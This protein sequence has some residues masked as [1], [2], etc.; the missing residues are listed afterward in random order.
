MATLQY[1]AADP[2]GGIG[3]NRSHWVKSINRFVSLFGTSGAGANGDNSVRAYDPISNVWSYLKPNTDPSQTVQNRDNHV[4]LY[5]HALDQIWITG[6]SHLE[7]LPAGTARVSGRFSVATRAWINQDA[8]IDTPNGAFVGVI[9]N[10]IFQFAAAIDPACDWSEASNSGLIFGGS[11]QGNPTNRCFIIEPN[12]AGPEPYVMS[13]VFGSMPPPRDQ[14]MNIMVAVG[15]DW[16]LF[17]GNSSNT[18]TNDFWKFTKATRQWTRLPDPP[19][20]GGYLQPA[21][22]YDS[23]TREILVWVNAR[24]FI[25]NIASNAWRTDPLVVPDTGN[26]VC[27]YSPTGKIHIFSGGSNLNT[28]IGRYETVGVKLDSSTPPPSTGLDIAPGTWKALPFNTTNAPAAG[29]GGKH[30]RLAECSLNG[31]V[32][33]CGGDYQTPQEVHCWFGVWAVDLITNTWTIE[34]PHMGIAGEIMPPACDEVGWAWD[35]KRK[36]F[37]MLPG[38]TIVPGTPL[39]ANLPTP[40]GTVVQKILCFDPVAKKWSDPQVPREPFAGQLPKNATYDSVNDCIWRVGVDQRGTV[41]HRLDCASKT[42]S[43]YQTVTATDGTYI[44][45]VGLDF[46]YIAINPTTQKIYVIDPINYRLFEFDCTN[47]AITI[48]APIPVIDAA[49]VQVAKNRNPTMGDLT[50]VAVDVANNK[51]LYSMF[52]RVLDGQLNDA[53]SIV[54]L[55]IFD[56]PTNTWTIDPMTQPEGRVVRGN[57]LTFAPIN[58]ALVVIGGLRQDAGFDSTLTHYFAYRY[59]AGGVIPPPPNNAEISVAL[60][61]IVAVSVIKGPANPLDWVGLYPDGAP[62]NGYLANGWAYV[63]SGNQT[64]PTVGKAAATLNFVKPASGIYEAR[65]YRNDSVNAADLLASDSFDVPAPPAGGTVNVSCP[66]TYVDKTVS[67]NVAVA[68]YRVSLINS[69]GAELQG[70]DV[71]VNTSPVLFPDVPVG[72]GY[73]IRGRTLNAQGG[74]IDQS[75]SAAFDVVE[76]NSIIKVVVVGTPGVS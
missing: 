69:A 16:Y 52:C 13:E 28:S 66:L 25:F 37:W 35:S 51:V 49:R 1:L 11:V 70:Q 5:V 56:P 65:F 26:Q 55:L 27:A 4:S 67:G 45:D 15:P 32:Y 7:A 14:G 22:T 30:L 42:W 74:I 57:G 6:G 68:N 46:E 31:K 41:W 64:K 38:Y 2:Q 39:G 62:N 34:Y 20:M 40:I 10:P 50:Q 53:S 33:F 8:G 21:V 59:G 58:N 29:G 73:K 12:P 63:G 75:M 76:S 54:S 36:V 43:E 72:T 47:H 44:N 71:P 24:L 18:P 3:F 17:S 19:H 60:T 9:K 48:K 61:D 23:D